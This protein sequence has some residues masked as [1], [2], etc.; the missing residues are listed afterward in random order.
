MAT[1][2]KKTTTAETARDLSHIAPD[3]RE[4]AVEIDDLKA[5]LR[6]VRLH[7]K[8]NLAAVRKSLRRF[9][10]QQPLVVQKSTMTV[11]A[12]NARLD[13]AKQLGW[14]HIAANVVDMSDKLA[15][16]FALADN[17]TAELAEWDE[18]GLATQL[19]DLRDDELIDFVGWDETE[20]DKL[21]EEVTGDANFKTTGS[22]EGTRE[23]TVDGKYVYRVLVECDDDKQ[24][25]AAIELLE[26][27]GFR[28]RAT[29]L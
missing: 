6:N 17:R 28:C 3:L 9:G 16:A 26:K 13:A 15:R 11:V 27:G 24:Q 20:I 14:K 23:E 19:A 8:R 7:D 22:S 18:Q 4:M 21:L 25:A 12:G 29:T 10:Q 1:R 2:K 5:D